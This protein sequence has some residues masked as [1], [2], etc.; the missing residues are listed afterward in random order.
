MTDSQRGIHTYIH[1]TDTQT[2]RQTGQDRQAG[3]QAGWDAY[4]ETGKDKTKAKYNQRGR[5]SKNAKIQ[6]Y[7]ELNTGK[8]GR[9]RVTEGHTDKV[10]YRQAV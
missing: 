2:Y 1:Q 4:R 3:R 8:K 10:T 5:E 9:G 7:S 6:Q